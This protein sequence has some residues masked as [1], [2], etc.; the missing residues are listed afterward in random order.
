[1]SQKT[2]DAKK[3]DWII[4]AVPL[5]TIVGLAILFF[6]VPDASNDV[7]SRIRFLFGDTLGTYYLVIGLGSTAT[8]SSAHP[9]RSRNTPS[10]RGAV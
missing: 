5:V 4:T 2:K 1:M 3:I 6:I 7:L 8:S 9:T 10:S